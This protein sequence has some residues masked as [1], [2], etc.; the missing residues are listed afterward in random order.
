[1]SY[2]WW[3]MLIGSLTGICCALTGTILVL[4]K[5]AMIG[6]A[7]SHTVLLGIVLAYLLSSQL[8][9]F[10]MF[11][12]AVAIGL[13]TSFFVQ[14]LHERNVKADAAIGVT[15]T[16]L[17]AIGVLLI[18]VY[19]DQIHLDL[20][21]VLYGEI[22]FSPLQT[23]E[24]AGM[25]VGPKAVWILGGLLLLILVVFGLLFKEIRVLTFDPLYAR[26]M[27]LPVRTI[28]YS[29]MTLVSLTIVAAFDIVGSI[30]VVSMLIVPAATAY[31]LARGLLHAL[32]L[33]ALFAVLA[34]LG[35]FWFA[36]S[37]DVS[38]SGSMSV[39]TGLL[40]TAVFMAQRFGL[41]K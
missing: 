1:M 15:F 40:F 17:F 37:L 20:D 10:W 26:T 30:L 33:A 8:G 7:I 22:A 41:V 31:L 36:W 3:V 19:A 39:F 6:D 11:V 14:W 4:R 16:T 12:G 32:L 38:I 2:E 24:F 28:H 34:A 13:L 35:G 27:G 25:S 23:L 18:S 5:M 9:G 29:M 21:H